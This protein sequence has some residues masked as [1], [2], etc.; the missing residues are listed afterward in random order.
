MVSETDDIHTTLIIEGARAHNLKSV[1]LKIPLGKLV[2]FA[3]PSGS[4]KTSIAF[5]TLLK[6]SK[7]RF[8]N[9]FP[10]A[11]KLFSERPPAVDVDRISPVLP[12]FGLPQINPILS[13]RQ[14]VA[15]S[16][17]LTELVQSLYYHYAVELCPFHHVPMAPQSIDRLLQNQLGELIQKEATNDPVVYFL[18]S[19]ETYQAKVTSR[20]LPSRSWNETKKLMVDFSADDDWWEIGRLKSSQLARAVEFLTLNGEVLFTQ[21]S[22]YVSGRSELFPF[23]YEKHSACPVSGCSEKS[24][25]TFSYELFGPLNAQ[26][27]CSA[28]QGFGATLKF[29]R[30]KMFTLEHSIAQGGVKILSSKHFKHLKTSFMNAC[31]KNN[32]DLSIPLKSQPESFWIWCMEGDHKAFDG[33]NSVLKY[34][35]SKM[36]KPAVRMFVRQLQNEVRCEVCEYTRINRDAHYFALPYGDSKHLT[37]KNLYQ[38]TVLELKRLVDQM[39][40][41]N[42][43][44]QKDLLI[45]MQHYL[46]HAIKLGTDHLQL[47]RKTKS[48]SAGE[49][50]RLV[51]V[52]YLSY[53]GT[54]SLFVFDEPGLGLGKAEMVALISGFREMAE[55]GNTVVMI[56]HSPYLQQSSD[57]LVVMGPGSGSDGGTV[58]FQGLPVDYFKNYKLHKSESPI[59]KLSVKSIKPKLALEL[60]GIEVYGRKYPDVKLF[61]SSLHWIT[62]PSGSGKSSVMTKL[63]ANE[64]NFQ[65]EGSYLDDRVGSFQKLELHQTFSNVLVMDSLVKRVSSRSTVGSSTEL[66]KPIRAY[67]SKTPRAKELGLVESHFSPNTDLGMCPSCEGSGRHVV[68]MQYMEDVEWPC[69]ECKGSG[70]NP[71]YAAISDGKLSFMDAWTMPLDKLN[72]QLPF[73]GKN[74][75]QKFNSLQKLNLTHLS[76]GRVVS[77]LSG[78]ERQRLMLHSYLAESPK[79]SLL[80]LENISFGLSERELLPMMDYLREVA[81]LGNVILVIDQNEFFNDHIDLL[82]NFQKS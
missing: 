27:A 1:S 32:V 65:I 70:L 26:G 67:F 55:Q 7:R 71:K 81:A 20:V 2:C 28:C 39:V 76:L 6:E 30:E 78:G 8:I 24:K 22:V 56:D 5:H 48:L 57:Y 50:Q 46:H 29:D 59:A 66:N 38:T 40:H 4:G 64:L 77:T 3:G 19:K 31:E 49:Y 53:Q 60:K 21:C 10:N 23:Q 80:V 11:L 12:V 34:L 33:F 74:P 13:S 61:Q 35:E 54:D 75:A 25:Q 15:D 72:K 16:M 43:L 51:L 52:R 42:L 18:V 37:L 9:S 68:E 82:I 79:N 36:Y 62:G 14:N 58:V 41:S 69:E 45:R 47:Y 63:L 17:G 73:T 44:T